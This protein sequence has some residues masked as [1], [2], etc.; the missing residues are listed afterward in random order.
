MRYAAYGSNLDTVHFHDWCE[1][2][3][4]SKARLQ[5]G[6]PVFIAD[7]EPNFGYRTRFREGGAFN[8]TPKI[9]TCT[10]AA[11]FDID[12]ATLE[13]LDEKEGVELE[14]YERI[15]VTVLDDRGGSERVLSYRVR[16]ERV[17]AHQPPSEAYLNFV[18]NGLRAHGHDTAQLERIARN[19]PAAPVPDSIF[20]YG[21]LMRDAARF[22]LV[23]RFSPRAIETTTVR[24]S[25]F[26]IDWYPGLKLD[27]RGLVHGECMRFE[28]TDALF[29]VLDAYEG[30]GGFG[31]NKFESGGG[32]EYDRVL[33]RDQSEHLCWTYEFK[34]AVIESARIGDGDWLKSGFSGEIYKK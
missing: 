15:E 11:I 28:R 14:R 1:K 20:V 4:H 33:V 10:P 22:D 18:R 13:A 5:N 34:G 12:D 8:L 2:N 6:K 29:E 32:S 31:Q 26:K 19:E 9:G 17:D 7:H 30:F 23:S 16:P 25:L 24:G 21:T 27:G 3:G